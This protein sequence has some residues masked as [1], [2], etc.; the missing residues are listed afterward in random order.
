MTET[1]TDAFARVEELI[2]EMMHTAARR[3]VI[4]TTREAPIDRALALAIDEFHTNLE[5]CGMRQ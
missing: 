1:A 2:A 4:R 5:W 3:P